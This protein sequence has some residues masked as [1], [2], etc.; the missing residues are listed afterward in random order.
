METGLM[1]KQTGQVHITKKLWAKLSGK[2]LPN[3]NFAKIPNQ[4]H[5]NDYMYYMHLE[6]LWKTQYIEGMKWVQG[7]LW[8]YCKPSYDNK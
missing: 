8:I 3:G 7:P 6:L 4:Q 1:K 5:S 2:H